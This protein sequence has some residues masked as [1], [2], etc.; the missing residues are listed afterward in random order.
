MLTA[1]EPSVLI[2][3]ANRHLG[4]S[5][6]SRESMP[7]NLDFRSLSAESLALVGSRG[8]ETGL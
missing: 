8:V 6:R 4:P 5:F 1:C 2:W 3:F 7:A